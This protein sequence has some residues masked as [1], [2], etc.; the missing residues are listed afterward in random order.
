MLVMGPTRSAAFDV[1]GKA[2]RHGFCIQLRLNLCEISDKV[3]EKLCL[4]FE[5]A[6]ALKIGEVKRDY[7][8]SQLFIF[9]KT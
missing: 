4:E 5:W 2:C 9:Q 7:G 6:V 8:T 1:G 3:L